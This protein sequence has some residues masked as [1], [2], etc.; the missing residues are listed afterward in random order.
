MHLKLEGTEPPG[1]PLVSPTGRFKAATPQLFIKTTTKWA[2]ICN[3]LNL[4]LL[5][6]TVIN[7]FK[8]IKCWYLWIIESKWRRV[9]NHLLFLFALQLIFVTCPIVVPSLHVVD[10][11]TRLDIFQDLGFTRLVN[12]LHKIF[13]EFLKVVDP[14]HWAIIKS[15]NSKKVISIFFWRFRFLRMNKSYNFCLPPQPLEFLISINLAHLVEVKTVE[16]PKFQARILMV[17]KYI[18]IYYYISI[19]EH[20]NLISESGAISPLLCKTPF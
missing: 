5:L 12:F 6:T 1:L 3:F 17:C 14:I 8:F 9:I 13:F 10:T 7:K 4:A 15:L 11:E 19:E 20:F 18:L 16:L 2:K